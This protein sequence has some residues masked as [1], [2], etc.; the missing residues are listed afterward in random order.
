MC[1]SQ[2]ARPP[3]SAAPPVADSTDWWWLSFV[4]DERNAGAAIVQGADILEAAR[5]A[6]AHGCNPGGEV[7][8]VCLSMFGDA[9]QTDPLSPLREYGANRLIPPEELDAHG[10]RK[11]K[12]LPPETQRSLTGEVYG[13][14]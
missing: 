8:G 10:E 6:H 11:L 13:D 14:G 3:L 12:D 7:M 4:V 2:A 5:S 1:L 9:I